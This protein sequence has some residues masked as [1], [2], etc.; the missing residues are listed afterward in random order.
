MEHIRNAIQEVN[1]RRREEMEM[2]A[3]HC[4]CRISAAIEEKRLQIERIDK[5]IA[6]LRT[7]L[8]SLSYQEA[9]YEQIVGE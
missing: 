9:T 6:E 8:R 5:Q 2:A 1:D 4:V 3:R 7:E